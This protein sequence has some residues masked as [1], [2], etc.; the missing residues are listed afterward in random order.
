MRRVLGIDPG[1]QNTGFGVVEMAGTRLVHV[2]H[3]TIRSS[4]RL[5]LSARLVR[6]YSGLREALECHAP[7]EVSVESIFQARNAQT[8]LKL[9]H[10]RG[11]ALLA[12][13]QS[14][15][16]MVEYTPMQVKSAVVGYGRAEKQQVQE[17]VRRLLCLP[18]RAGAD[19]SDALAVA[20]CHLQSRRTAEAYARR[21]VVP[22]GG[23][24]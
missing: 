9:G 12:V 24:R 15:L 11:V 16:P 5:S 3:G 14:G 7:D 19:A 1:T 23:R 10:A 17:M 21:R 13:E 8:A 6:I 2:V 18:E 4:P 22:R 20:I